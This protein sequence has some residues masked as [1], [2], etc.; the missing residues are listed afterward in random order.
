[1]V[2]A[3]AAVGKAWAHHAAGIMCGL[4]AGS[5]FVFG[6]IDYATG[7]AGG[8]PP[9]VDLAIMVTAVA[10]AAVASKPAREG[11]A[12]LIP[13]DPDNPVHSLALALA[14]ILL[15]TQVATVVF[16]DVLAAE[17][18]AAPLTIADLLA[19]EVP[20]LVFAAAGVGLYIRRNLAQSGD[21]LGFVRPAWW[22]VALA[23]AAAGVFFGI[24][25]GAGWL[26]DA[27]TPSVAAEVD[28]TT[29]HV[30]GRLGD[31]PGLLALGL[32]PGICEEALFRGALQPRLGLVVT[33]V[34]FTAIHAEYGLSLDVPTI[35]AIAIGLGLIRKYTNTTAS[36]TCHATYN[37]VV[38][39]GLTGAALY[40]G[41]A[42]EAV[43]ICV[44]GYVVWS[45]RRRPALT[46]DVVEQT[47]LS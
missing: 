6:A 8:N 7:G 34:L 18:K 31:T 32:L 39:Y 30:F 24:S 41:I 42:V 25:Q 13:I 19:Q 36:A 15:G 5:L 23:L 4:L 17:R 29:Q 46:G 43:L 47:S 37:L 11:A 3:N 38:G 9:A 35:F 27:L 1:V 10:A 33:A 22:H 44:V 40:G 26:S 28:R 12:R 2:T 45:R 20:F 21:R 14:V 16:T